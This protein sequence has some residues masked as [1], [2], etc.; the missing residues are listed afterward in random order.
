MLMMLLMLWDD[1]CVSVSKQMT[2]EC[3]VWCS[4]LGIGVGVGGG[5]TTTEQG[6][7]QGEHNK[8]MLPVDVVDAGNMHGD[9]DNNNDNN[10]E[11]DDDEGNEFGCEAKGDDD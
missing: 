5:T 6:M 4:V 2:P 8:M 1:W 7:M 9:D 3:G 10:D 11:V